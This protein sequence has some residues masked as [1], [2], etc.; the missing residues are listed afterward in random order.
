[1]LR[2]VAIRLAGAAVIP[3]DLAQAKV[4]GSGLVDISSKALVRGER[5]STAAGLS[6]RRLHQL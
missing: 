3:V 4:C 5:A 2:A 6:V 1:M